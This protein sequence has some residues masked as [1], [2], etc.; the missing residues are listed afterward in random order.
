MYSLIEM[1]CV[2]K[3]DKAY[4]INPEVVMAVTVPQD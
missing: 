4:K 3:T 1:C 2:L